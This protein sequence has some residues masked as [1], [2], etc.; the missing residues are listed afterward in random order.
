[1]YE[2]GLHGIGSLVQACH[3]TNSSK[4][5]CT[6]VPGTGRPIINGQDVKVFFQGKALKDQL[7][8]VVL[9]CHNHPRAVGV[10]GITVR[11][12]R[13][14]YCP[15]GTVQRVATVLSWKEKTKTKEKQGF[16]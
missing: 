9:G 1:M 3:S 13:A 6:Q 16:K 14:L 12:A 8:P 11:V 10:V 5:P 7:Y 4:L 15:I 2:V